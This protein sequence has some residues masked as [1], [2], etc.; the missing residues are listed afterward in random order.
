M[1]L[2]KINPNKLRL[3]IVGDYKEMPSEGMEVITAA[4]YNRARSRGISSTSFSQKSVL[5]RLFR[6]ISFN[7]HIAIFTH[8]PGIGTFYI[9]TLLKIIFPKLYIYWI[10]SRPDINKIP[11]IPSWLPKVD[12]IYIGKDNDTL[13]NYAAKNYVTIKREIIGIDMNRISTNHPKQRCKYLRRFFNEMEFYEGMPTLLHVGHIRKS[14]G[15][16]LLVELKL[17]LQKKVNILVIASPSL[18]YDRDLYK[19]LIDSQIS[20]YRKYLSN[21]SDVYKC[22]DMYL[23]PLDPQAGGAID[24]PLSVIEA[25]ACELPVIS[26]DFGALRENLD[27]LPG[28]VF[29]DRENFLDMTIANL[30]KTKTQT[31][32]ASSLPKKFDLNYLIDG[33]IDKHV[34]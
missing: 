25:L 19:K 30:G 5:T 9:T 29:T 7:P 28:I 22:A 26:T 11:Y 15:L 12:C 2:K 33:I 32:D 4:F 34:L 27:N 3:L 6:V 14:R 16:D 13:F 10:G 17:K 21:L 24:F 20:V 23:F 1:K 18:S 8:G 31:S